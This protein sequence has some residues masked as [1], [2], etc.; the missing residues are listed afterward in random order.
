L[1]TQA[2]FASYESKAEASEWIDVF[3]RIFVMNKEYITRVNHP[4]PGLPARKFYD[5]LCLSF[6]E[7]AKAILD[8]INKLSD[9]K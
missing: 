4:E 6:N 9:V 7:D 1:A 2:F 3:N 5:T 8:D